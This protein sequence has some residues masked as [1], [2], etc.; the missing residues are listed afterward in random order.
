MSKLGNKSKCF[1]MS[2]CTKEP[3]FLEEKRVKV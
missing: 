2:C 1:M 3:F